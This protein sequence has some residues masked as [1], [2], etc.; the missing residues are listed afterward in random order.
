MIQFADLPSRPDEPTDAIRQPNPD[1]DVDDANEPELQREW[2][3]VEA[4]Q[5]RALSAFVHSGKVKTACA[6]VGVKYG[7]WYRWRRESR[8]FERAY[9]RA[10]VLLSGEREAA[11]E[12]AA[13]GIVVRR[14]LLTAILARPFSGAQLRILL[15]LLDRSPDPGGAACPMR[16]AELAWAA[17]LQPSGGF[18]RALADLEQ[19]GV[20]DVRRSA[21]GQLSAVAGIRDVSGWIRP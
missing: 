5:Q 21:G 20:V 18:R 2:S 14:G 8:E 11:A 19:Q 13:G 12:A 9:Q 17:R 3:I 6:A 4:K 1:V 15:A 7:T 10:L 16:V